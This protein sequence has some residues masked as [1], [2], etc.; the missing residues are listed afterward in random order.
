MMLEASSI[1]LTHLLIDYEV[2]GRVQSGEI[3]QSIFYEPKTYD[4]L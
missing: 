3:V 4:N 1:K 2:A